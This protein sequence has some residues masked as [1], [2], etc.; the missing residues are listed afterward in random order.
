MNKKTIT[1]LITPIEISELLNVM[2]KINKKNGSI[3]A[4]FS[5]N[6]RDDKGNTYI[7]KEIYKT[8]ISKDDDEDFFK[9]NNG[10]TIISNDITFNKNGITTHFTL[11]VIDI[12]NGEQ[13]LRTI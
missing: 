13:T 9:M 3:D 7:S 12:V 5:S 4:L 2:E 1:T 8:I 10:L 11:E 6:V